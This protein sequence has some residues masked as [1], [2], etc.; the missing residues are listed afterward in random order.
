M[1]KVFR[2]GLK[3]NDMFNRVIGPSQNFR[4]NMKKLK[5][6]DL[7]NGSMEL[8]FQNI[9]KFGIFAPPKFGV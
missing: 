7:L 9:Q 3:C 1:C 4:L 2:V 6:Y 5:F 8:V